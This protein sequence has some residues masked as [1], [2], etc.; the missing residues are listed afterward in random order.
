[1]KN[2]FF[3]GVTPCAVAKMYE[4]FGGAYVLQLQSGNHCRENLLSHVHLNACIPV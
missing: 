1:M 2:T 3:R 4:H